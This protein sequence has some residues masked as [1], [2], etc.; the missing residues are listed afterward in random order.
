ML[1][2]W[3][4]VRVAGIVKPAILQIGCLV[5]FVCLAGYLPADDWTQWRGNN[6]DG[7]WHETGVITSF[8][9]SDLEPLWRRPIGT[10]YS[11]PTVANGKVLLMDFD[12]AKQNESVRC[13][14]AKTG[15]VVWSLTYLSEYRISYTA[16]PRAAVTIV[17][18]RA[19]CLGAMGR[20]HCLNINDGA[21]LWEKD[22]DVDYQ[23]SADRRM[24]IWG[25]ASSPIAVGDNV[26]IQLGAKE[27]SVV[28]FNQESGDEVWRSL[29]DRGQYASPVLVKQNGTEVLVC[30][31]GDGV[32]GL[33]PTTGTPYWQH[34]FKPTRMPIGVATPV[35]NG[36]K[37]FLTSFYDGAMM[38]E[39]SETS[40]EV[41]Q[42]WHLIG[43]NERKT[44]ALHSIISTPIWIGDYIYGV[45]S[46]GELRCIRA[47][48]GE[49]VWEDLSAVERQRWATIHFVAHGSN[50]WMLNE[51]GELMIGQLTGD[52][53]N[54][55][56]RETILTP[57]QMRTPNRK[58]GVC[59]SHPAFAN[60]C[61]FLRND[62]E[63]ICIDLA[64]PKK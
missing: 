58:G 33:N 30:W 3:D 44:A 56:S 7:V 51:Q 45:D 60:R 35:V 13:F 55:T 16:G 47:S 49:R 31:T 5:Y 14:D 4:R 22:L 8:E 1:I 54:V 43:P 62:R 19:F 41:K 18:D 9:K 42:L 21:V 50:T 15:E 26:I 25:I 17:G 12:E 20:L 61:I 38:L 29:N 46:Y 10:G 37:I 24:P 40:M 57:D 36:N 34:P 53:L 2:Q 39:M 28:A 59:W 23:V 6:R 52:G 48:D 27:A 63:L 32:A 64:A 11:S